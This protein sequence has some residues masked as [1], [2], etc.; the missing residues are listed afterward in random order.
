MDI[1]GH[2]WNVRQ[3]LLLEIN[4]AA[5]SDLNFVSFSLNKVIG[6]RVGT[7]EVEGR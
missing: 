7:A 3:P 6:G 4:A 1:R 5:K 2:E